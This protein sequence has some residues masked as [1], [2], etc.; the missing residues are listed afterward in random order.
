V[1]CYT[2]SVEVI[3]G[4][5]ALHKAIEMSMHPDPEDRSLV[6]GRGLVNTTG[7][8]I[9]PHDPEGNIG[10]KRVSYSK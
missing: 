4:S 3:L 8:E 6:V 1:L 7:E 9:P 2:T 5:I 10:K